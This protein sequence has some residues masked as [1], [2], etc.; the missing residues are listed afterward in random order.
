M[1]AAALLLAAWLTPAVWL[2]I[3][4]LIVDR[5]PNGLWVGLAVIVVPLVALGV[6][7]SRRDT[8]ASEAVFPV[9]AL[10]FTVGIL[11]WANLSLAGDVS[12]WLG[13]PRWYGIVIAAA[14][15]CL[16]A[17]VPGTGRLATALL[18]VAALGV[19]V[20][21]LDLARASGVGPIGAWDRVASRTAFRFPSSSPWVTDGGDLSAT[22]GRAPIRFD[23]EH[24]VTAAAAGRLYAYAVDGVRVGDLE[25]TLAPG[26]SVTFRTGDRI[27]RNSTARLRFESDKR[28]P[29][30]PTSGMSW[31]AGRP[32]NWPR[33]VGL[34]VTVLFGALA[35]CR[36]GAPVVTP[37]TMVALVAAGGLMVFLWGQGWAVYSLLASPDLF[38]GSVTADRLLTLPALV[39]DPARRI[40]QMSMLV[41]GLAAF[42]A[43]SIG[44]RECLATLDRTGGGEIGRDLGLWSGVIA[45]AGLGSLWHFDCWALVLLALGIAASSVSPSFFGARATSSAA[46]TVAGVVG[47]GVFLALTVTEQLQGGADGVRGAI[48]AYPAVVAVPAAALVLWLHRALVRG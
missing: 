17:V 2:S 22:Y 29:G 45:V 18:L 21:L 3:P 13:W 41:G 15:A 5:G 46:V 32:L 10:L 42:L 25:W 7:P 43:S 11:F 19:S 8:N 9:V 37:R 47:L 1:T 23:E 48:L 30:A 4:A 44:L 38:L 28:V 26:Q 39:D 34:V 16:L 36:T 31:A 35:F 27:Q 40:V 33:S 20:P 12:V 14:G 24:R 6:A